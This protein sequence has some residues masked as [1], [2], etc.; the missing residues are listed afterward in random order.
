VTPLE[1]AG[2]T[3]FILVLFVGIFSTIFGIPG[4]VIILINVTLY[5]LITGFD[6]IGI[7]IIIILLMISILAEATDFV[8]GMSGAARFEISKRG[9]WVS[10]I[11]GFAGAMVM[12]PV[13]FGLGTVVGTFLGGFTGVLGVELLRQTKLRPALRA[14]YGAILRRVTGILVKGFCALVMTIITMTNIYS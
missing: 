12:T 11:G 7:A 13:L 8:L 3:I 1:T 10:L 5:A 14:G 9:I 4:T 2:L 6:R